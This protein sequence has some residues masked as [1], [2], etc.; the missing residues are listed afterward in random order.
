M[1]TPDGGDRAAETESALGCDPCT[2]T[3]TNSSVSN[4]RSTP[5]GRGYSAGMDRRGAQLAMLAGGGAGSA[6]FGAAELTAAFVG[7]SPISA[8]SSW[9]IDL[10]PTWLK[11]VVIALAGTSDKLVLLVVLVVVV[12][13]VA[14]SA[15]LLERARPPW[16]AASF[17]ALGMVA[18]VGILTRSGADALSPVPMVLGTAVAVLLV[19]WFTTRLRR[20]DRLAAAGGATRRSVLI[21]AAGAAAFGVVAALG[22]QGLSAAGRALEAARRAVRLPTPVVAAPPIPPGADLAVPGTASLITANEDFYRIDTAVFLPNLDPGGWRLR[23]SGM[24]ERPIEI[25]YAQLLD[26]PMQ[27]SRITLMCV[28]NPVGGEY[29]STATWL[30]YPVQKLLEEARPLPG[31]DMVLSRSSDGFTAGTPLEALTDG[32]DALIA[33][34]MN[35]QPLPRQHGFPARMV[36]PGLYGYVSATKWLVE[37]EVTRF[38]Q[39]EAYWTQRGWG[40]RG[41]IKLS[42]RIDV[43]RAGAGLELGDVVVAG[44]AWQQHTGISAVQ[45]SVDGGDWYDA[46]LGTELSVD[47]WRQWRWVWNATPGAHTLRVRA[48]NAAGEAQEEAEQGV[49]PD[50]A[51]GLHTV[52]VVVG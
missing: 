52:Q 20:G 46:D 18:L 47:T 22:A 23:I 29:I 4:L 34:G 36:V 5:S 39:V 30:G 15:G 12:L 49:L 24:V 41:P 44:V 32:R 11:D 26:L 10:T 13:G 40:V 8:V 27:E 7:E 19:R 42:S 37:L 9:V 6:G 25:G 2:P 28:S 48:I 14:L 50:G 33:V 35:G 3:G 21:G 43:P 17:G 45:V 51:T 1:R 38:D 31:A 16:G